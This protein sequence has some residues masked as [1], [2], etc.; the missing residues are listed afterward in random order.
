MDVD[1]EVLGLISAKQGDEQAWTMLFEQHFPAV[2][3]YCL[4]LTGG[5]QAMAEEIAQ[6]AFVTAARRINRFRAG[7]GT[8]RTWVHGIA[9]KCFAKHVLKDV[10]RKQRETRFHAE[11][12]K[13]ENER[14]QQL[15][16]YETLAQLPIHYRLVLEGKYLE[17]LTVNEIAETQGCTVKAIESRLGRARE[18]FAQIYKRLS[19]P[20]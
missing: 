4:S 5:Q 13:K 16:V 1:F 17:G 11:S 20:K 18:K 12:A 8:F 10:R 3:R 2:Y 7:R 19:Y 14:Q 9:R 6:Q 15:L